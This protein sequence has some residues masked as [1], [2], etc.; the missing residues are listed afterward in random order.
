MLALWLLQLCH[1][2]LIS[3]TNNNNKQQCK[4]KLLVTSRHHIM[5][6]NKDKSRTFIGSSQFDVQYH[7]SYN[8]N[9]GNH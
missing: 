9:N 8:G 4:R 1:S 6:Q 5:T 2:S 7:A 3:K